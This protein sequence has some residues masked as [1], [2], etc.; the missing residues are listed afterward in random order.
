MKTARLLCVLLVSFA[1]CARPG[2]SQAEDRF[3]GVREFIE[4]ELSRQQIPSLAVAVSHRGKIVWEEGFG[5][6]NAATQTPATSD[7]IFRICSVSKVFTATAIMLLVERGKLE[8]DKPVNDYLGKEKLVARAGKARDATIRRLAN[9]TSGLPTHELIFYEGESFKRQPSDRIETQ[10]ARYGNIVWAP[11]SKPTY[12]NLAS[13]ILSHIVARRSGESFTQFM[14][15]EVFDPLGMNRSSVRLP[16]RLAQFAAVGH[17]E[18]KPV[19]MVT[20]ATPGAG[21]VWCSAHDLV[22]FGMF[23]LKNDLSDQRAI[24]SNKSLDEMKVTTS[25]APGSDFGIGWGTDSNYRGTGFRAVG[26]H[27]GNVGWHS[28][29][30]LLPEDDVAI[31]ILVNANGNILDPVADEVLSVVVP[32]FGARRKAHLKARKE[33]TSR[34]KSAVS[35]KPRTPSNVVGKWTG[36]LTTFERE[37]PMT[38][39]IEESGAASAAIGEQPKT[40]LRSSRIRGGSLTADLRATIDTAD[41][42]RLRPGTLEF[43]LTFRGDV[44]SGVVYANS[45]YGNAEYGGYRL[46]HWVKLKRSE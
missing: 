35:P 19:P 46:N 34:K 15:K 41:T 8:L 23:H 14:R 27:G 21:E 36:S 28:L 2:I 25:R 1:L 5:F 40:P 18:G 43:D 11:G 17:V 37:V 24:L 16:K 7:T 13:G 4:T 32:E 44:L 29:L 30:V 20:N 33:A 3:D 22:R 9:H 26:H 38:I 10:I 31:A 12:S 6:A 45:L 39:W 42:R